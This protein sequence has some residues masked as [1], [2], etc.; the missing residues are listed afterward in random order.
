MTAQRDTTKTAANENRPRVL[1]LD[2]ARRAD[3]AARDL[4]AMAANESERRLVGLIL[5]G[6]MARAGLA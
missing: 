6:A 3:A 4:A 1:V 5:E 2:V